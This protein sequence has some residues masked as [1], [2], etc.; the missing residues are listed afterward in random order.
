[1]KNQKIFNFLNKILYSSF[2]LWVLLIF[3]K[4]FNLKPEINISLFFFLSLLLFSIL[5]FKQ[6]LKFLKDSPLFL[7]LILT[8]YFFWLILGIF[9]IFLDIFV[10]RISSDLLILLLIV[11]WIILVY[12]YKFDGRFSIGLALGFLVLCPF[13]LSFNNKP[14]ADKAAIW[15][16]L[17]LVVGV[18]QLFIEYLKEERKDEK[19]KKK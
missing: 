13:L 7:K 8:N 6:I 17:F 4:R 9:L 12:R 1:M 14:I 3:L 5:F 10:F 19:I 16:Y 18:I 15:A 2:F 11:L